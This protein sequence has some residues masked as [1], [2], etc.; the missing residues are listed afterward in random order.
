MT[1]VMAPI[2]SERFAIYFTFARDTALYQKATLWLGHCVYN[3]ALCRKESG[4]GFSPQLERFRSVQQAAHYGFHATLKPPFR[5][6]ARTTRTE[7]VDRLVDF[8]SSIQPFNCAP[9]KVASIDNFIA[10]TLSEDCD[11]LNQL[12][13]QC[14]QSFESFRA[15]LNE[16]EMQKR[17][18]PPLTLR[19]QQLLNQWGYP[20]L[21]DEFRFHITLTDRLSDDLV[22]DA[23]HRLD[24]EFSPLLSS[25]LYIDRI[26]LFHQK[27]S[28]TPFQL[29]QTCLLGDRYQPSVNSE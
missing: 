17:L 20:Y 29:V 8:A 28:A 14:V 12:A 9:L 5:L 6:Q 18:K 26:C 3:E 22:E 11:E 25:S 10:L 4:D 1:Q 21:F 23:L 24:L 19:Q 27:D 2:N 13:R 7:L 16:T 15:P